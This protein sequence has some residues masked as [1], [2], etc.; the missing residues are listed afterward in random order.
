LGDTVAAREAT[1]AVGLPRLIACA[2]AVLTLLLIQVGVVFLLD[3]N[4]IVRVLLPATMAGLLPLAWMGRRLLGVVIMAAGLL[5]NLVVMVANGGLMPIAP[6]TVRAVAGPDY[7][8]RYEPGERL[9]SSKDVLLAKSDTRLQPLSDH[10]VLPLE[11]WLRQAVSPGDLVVAVGI[12]VTVAGIPGRQV[13]DWAKKGR[14]SG[15]CPLE[16]TA[17]P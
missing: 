16:E 1:V 17:H 5:L 2:G 4:P 10:I 7:F 13:R 12:A 15:G 6:E 14:S 8:A 11:G 3:T 9:P